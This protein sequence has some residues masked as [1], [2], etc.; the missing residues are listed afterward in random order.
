MV[1]IIGNKKK[2]LGKKWEDVMTKKVPQALATA[3]HWQP[4]PIFDPVPDWIINRLD[5]AAI[6]QMAK[7]QLEFGR[8]VLEAQLKATKAAQEI[9]GNVR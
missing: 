7:I 9:I 8:N 1:A 2:T 4:G 3:L 5:R 6:I